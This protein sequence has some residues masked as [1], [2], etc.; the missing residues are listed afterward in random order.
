MIQLLRLFRLVRLVRLV[1]T[2]E[3]LDVLYI[4]TTAIRGMSSILFFAVMLLSVML[5]TVSLGLTQ[6]LHAYYFVD[7]PGPMTAAEEMKRTKI[8]EYFGSF[9]RCLLSMFELALANWPPVTRLLAEE[10]SEWF[11]VICVFFKL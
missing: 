5:M 3:G 4:M 2:L 8:Y 7:D 6:V 1:R 11:M 9:T 10:V